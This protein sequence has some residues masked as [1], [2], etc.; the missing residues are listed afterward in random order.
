MAIDKL[1]RLNAAAQQFPIVD[2]QAAAREAAAI[3]VMSQAQ[4]P[5][6]NIKRSAQQMGG[7]VASALG[8]VQ[9]QSMANTQ[10]NLANVIDLL[11]KLLDCDIMLI[12]SDLSICG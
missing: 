9:Q 4:M 6:G 11:E 12:V 5:T 8:Q 1:A 3:N 7:N 2:E 10:Q